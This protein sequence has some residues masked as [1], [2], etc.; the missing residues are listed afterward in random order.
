MTLACSFDLFSY[1]SKAPQLG[2]QQFLPQVLLMAINK[3]DHGA[4][5][6]QVGYGA[7]PVRHWS[8][9]IPYKLSRALDELL[10]VT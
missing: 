5:A 3:R 8:Y 2:S 9:S 4:W 1:L 7:R 10:N 6:L